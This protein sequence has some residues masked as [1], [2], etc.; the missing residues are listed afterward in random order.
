MNEAEV[1]TLKDIP[2]G[3]MVTV[4][5]TY[6]GAHATGN[7]DPQTVEIL[8]PTETT[9]E[10]GTTTTVTSNVSFTNTN[11]DTHR[12]GHGIENKFT[13]NKESGS[14][15]WVANGGDGATSGNEVEAK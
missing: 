1:V 8:A 2:I 10:D 12:G 5:E 3:T 9:N 14:W 4:T 13:F 7:T 11:N 6:S 15:G